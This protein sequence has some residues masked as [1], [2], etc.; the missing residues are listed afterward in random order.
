MGV[1]LA[2]MFIFFG[3]LE[4]FTIAVQL[5]FPPTLNCDYID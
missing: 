5:K 1:F 4:K 3:W 2:L